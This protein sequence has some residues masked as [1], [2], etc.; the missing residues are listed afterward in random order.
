MAEFP[1]SPSPTS[2]GRFFPQIQ[3]VGKPD[4]VT[5]KWLEG[6]GFKSSNDRYLQGIL[7]SL[8]FTNTDN[9]PTETWMRYRN[10]QNARKVMAQA[11]IS[12]YPSLF[13]TYPDANRKDD[14]ALRNFFSTNTSVNQ[15]TVSLIVRTF[16]AL[17]DLADFSREAALP[18]VDDQDTTETGPSQKEQE[19]NTQK[20]SFTNGGGYTINVNIQ[21]Q[22]PATDDASIYDKLFESLKK[23]LMS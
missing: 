22:L 5:L 1:Y 4:K 2:I 10:K 6:I 15:S 23:H 18:L 11:I 12:A 9:K 8:G 13:R 16:K 17:V 3:I 14:E 19:G 20:I 21:L 7:R